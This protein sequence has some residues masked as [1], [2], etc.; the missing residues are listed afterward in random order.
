MCNFSINH[1][2]ES[3]SEVHWTSLREIALPLIIRNLQ[4][5]YT[6]YANIQQE[7]FKP[8]QIENLTLIFYLIMLCWLIGCFVL[9][10]ERLIFRRNKFFIISILTFKHLSD[11]MQNHY[12]LISTASAGLLSLCICLIVFYLVFQVT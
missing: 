8:I 7:Q 4:P 3:G 12:N 11:F 9:I 2:L 10:I 6:E 5:D 1:N